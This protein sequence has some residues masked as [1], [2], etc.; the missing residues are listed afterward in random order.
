MGKW[1]AEVQVVNEPDAWHTN[2]LVF[3]T[4]E[5]AETYA[6]DLFSRW[7]QTTAW[8]AVEI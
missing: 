2:A 4:K 7:T 1:K 3:D 8:R 5:E 6:K